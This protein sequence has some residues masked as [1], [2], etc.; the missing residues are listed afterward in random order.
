MKVV[1][2]DVKR[3]HPSDVGWRLDAEEARV[4]K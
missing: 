1:A 2:A 3:D 4:P